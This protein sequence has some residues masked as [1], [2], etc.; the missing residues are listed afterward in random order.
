MKNPDLGALSLNELART[1]K[2]AKSNVYRYFETREAVLLALLWIEWSTWQQEFL[3]SLAR[4]SRADLKLNVLIQ[5]LV[6]SLVERR[7][8]CA[9]TAALPTVVEQNLSDAAIREFK[10]GTLQFLRHTGAALEGHCPRLTGE[11]YSQLLYD[12][13]CLLAGLYPHANPASSVS[14]VLKDPDLGF[15]KRD[16]SQDLERILFLLAESLRKHRRS[17]KRTKDA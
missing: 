7:L 13:A 15:F 9:L 6:R 5:R 17:K 10:Q 14:R 12:A 16:L 3:Q 4:S 2:M 1:A 8:L 11:M